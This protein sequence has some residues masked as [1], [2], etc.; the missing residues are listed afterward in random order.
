MAGG[1]IDGF[2]RKVKPGQ[3]LR[4]LAN[5]DNLNKVANAL[6]DITGEGC[7]IDKPTDGSPWVIR[8]TG[9]KSDNVPLTMPHDLQVDIQAANSAIYRAQSENLIWPERVDITVNGI[10]VYGASEMHR[11]WQPT[12]GLK[13]MYIY[14]HFSEYRLDSEMQY[15]SPPTYLYATSTEDAYYNDA[16]VA[17]IPYCRVEIPEVGKPPK[18]KCLLEGPLRIYCYRGDADTRAYA[19]RPANP[20]RQIQKSK[21][22]DNSGNGELPVKVRNINA[23]TDGFYNEYPHGR[24]RIV[25]EEGEEKVEWLDPDETAVAKNSAKAMLLRYIWHDSLVMHGQPYWCNVDAFKHYGNGWIERY[26]YDDIDNRTPAWLIAIIRPWAM[27]IW[28]QMAEAF[29]E[30]CPDFIGDKMVMAAVMGRD[31]EWKSIVDIVVTEEEF[32]LAIEDFDALKEWAEL[33]GG[34][35][36]YL[37]DCQDMASNECDTIQAQINNFHG[38]DSE[39]QWASS[40]AQRQSGEASG[41]AS[42]FASLDARITAL[43]QRFSS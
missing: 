28:N 29:E 41:M 8:Y 27:E 40:E 10:A 21:T 16:L 3:P 25:T 32:D 26:I 9:D 43:E 2:F 22:I 13:Y 39:A 37:A 14:Q 34:Q 20:N 5:V 15:I 30:R 1:Q 11:A 19:Q 18:I 38:F 4:A 33:V 36:G 23:G 7:T 24:Y 31:G 42:D 6:N 12:A 35:L 17:K